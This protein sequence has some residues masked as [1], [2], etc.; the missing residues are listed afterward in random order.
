MKNI[1][2]TTPFPTTGYYGP[3]YFCDRENE[4]ETLIGN[5]NG[6]LSTTLVAIRRIGKTGLIKHLQNKLSGTLICIYA[7]ILP[8]E[9]SVDFLN[10]LATAI[11]NA[12]PEKSGLGAKVWNFIKSLRPVISF[13][14]LSG[15]PNVSFNIQDK[16]SEHQIGTLFS[17]SGKPK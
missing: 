8:T 3:E 16:E 4:T 14:A 10:S 9:N 17:F 15:T 6:G 13:D 11:L 1:Y 5:V 7:D 12:V 2:P